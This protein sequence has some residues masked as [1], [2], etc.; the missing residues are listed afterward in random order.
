MKTIAILALWFAASM[1]FQKTMVKS[2]VYDLQ[3]MSRAE[4]WVVR[5]LSYSIL[6][7]LFVFG[8]PV[9]VYTAVKRLWDRWVMVDLRRYWIMM[10]IFCTSGVHGVLILKDYVSEDMQ[11][12]LRTKVVR[13][14]TELAKHA[15][16]VLLRDPTVQMFCIRKDRYG[17]GGVYMDKEL[18]RVLKMW[19][20]AKR[21]SIKDRERREEPFE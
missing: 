19:Q 5:A 2:F 12:N 7:L 20:D 1:I 15:D 17:L 18:P 9:I 11:Q 13:R 14:S 3:D 10:D 21:R 4:T 16:L 8:L 6:G